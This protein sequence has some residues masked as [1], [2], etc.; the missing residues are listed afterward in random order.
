M[1]ILKLFTNPGKFY[2]DHFYKTSGMMIGALWAI[3][4][5]LSTLGSAAVS[6]AFGDEAWVQTT[7]WSVFTNVLSVAVFAG[8]FV[9]SVKY[10]AA[11]DKKD[12]KLIHGLKLFL[13]GHLVTNSLSTIMMVILIPLAFITASSAFVTT[14]ISQL[15]I[16]DYD[17]VM[18]LAGQG[19]AFGIVGILGSC[20][21]VIGVVWG[22]VVEY[23]GTKKLTGASDGKSFLAVTLPYIASVVMG[24]ILGVI[25]GIVSA[26]ILGS[27]SVAYSIG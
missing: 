17:Q 24:M 27:T 25:S 1:G 2:Q 13:T 12:F 23:I 9:L 21:S 6:L 18:S 10:I 4:F 5:L 15:G 22:F 14:D 7:L 11:A 8:V 26:I 16:Q 3:V 20:V 19:V